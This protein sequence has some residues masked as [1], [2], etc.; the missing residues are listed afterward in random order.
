MS[1]NFYCY[2]CKEAFSQ[3]NDQKCPKCGDKVYG[4]SD[5]NKGMMSMLFSIFFVLLALAAYKMD[6]IFF[7]I[8]LTCFFIFFWIGFRKV[9]SSK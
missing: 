4:K 1:V 3:V 2:T 6:K 9:S 8:C 5:R 7:Y